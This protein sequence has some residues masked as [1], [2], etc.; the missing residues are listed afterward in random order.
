MGSARK[1][2]GRI[3]YVF[4]VGLTG[5][6]SIVMNWLVLLLL[7]VLNRIVLV[8]HYIPAETNEKYRKSIELRLWSGCMLQ[9]RR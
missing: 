9:N 6:K 2:F 4:K 5:G 3:S 7:L 1:D 8:R